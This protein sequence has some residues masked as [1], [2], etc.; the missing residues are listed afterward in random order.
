MR[1][2]VGREALSTIGDGD[3]GIND[4]SRDQGHVGAKEVGSILLLLHHVDS[5]PDSRN[6]G[7]KIAAVNYNTI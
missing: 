4:D 2:Y 5:T 3:S 6:S 1:H 7:K